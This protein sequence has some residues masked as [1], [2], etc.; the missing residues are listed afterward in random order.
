M[1]KLETQKNTPPLDSGI[2]DID[3]YMFDEEKPENNNI[4]ISSN[5]VIQK[6]STSKKE[7]TK[8]FELPLK[9]IYKVN[10]SIDQ[11]VMQMNPTFNNQSYQRF[12]GSGFQNAGFDGFTL[13]N[14]KDVKVKEVTVWE[15]ARSAVTYSQ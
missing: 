8:K 3:N 14:T 1:K 2:I 15:T 6:D 4:A 10:F 11:V 9:E 13:I 12:T 7:P 5:E